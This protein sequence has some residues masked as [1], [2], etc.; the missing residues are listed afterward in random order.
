MIYSTLT[1]VNASRDMIDAFGGYNHNLR[2][3]ENEFYDMKNMTS[4]YYPLLSPRGGR[5]LYSYPQGQ[6]TFN[7]NGIIAKD[8][9][10]RVEGTKLFI[11]NNEIQG[12]V[13]TDGPKQLISMGAYLIIMP[14]KKYVNTKDFTEYGDIEAS[15]TTTGEV[16][17][18]LCSQDGEGYDDVTISETEPAEPVNGTLWIDSSNPELHILKQYSETSSMWVQIPT[19][20]IKI[21]CQGIAHAFE[22]FDGVK[23][24]GIDTENIPQL[25]DLEG[26]TSVIWRLYKDENGGA[27]DYIVVIGMLDAT[28]SQSSSITVSRRM[29]L[30]D[31]IIESGNRL[32][33][34]RYGP[35]IDGE[36]VNEIYASKLGDFKNWNVYMGLGSDSYAASCGTDGQW[37]GA[38]AHLGYPLFWK[39]NFVHK[40]YGNMPANYQIQTTACKG[41]QKG[42][43]RSMAIVGET[44]FYKSTN[45]VCA[46]DGSLPTEVSGQFGGIKYTALDATLKTADPL[47]C[48]AVA[49]ADHNKYYIS[50]KSEMDD[51]WHLFVFDTRMGMWHREDN[52]WADA[53]CACDDNMYYIDHADKKIKT[54]SDVRFAREE[55]V[56]WFVETGTL[57]LSLP[58]NK[59]ISR[60]NIR[61]SLK[62]GTRIAIYIE[63]DSCG[64]WEFLWDMVGTSLRSFTVPIR[65][66][67]CDHFR[68]KIE[69]VGQA[70]IFSIAKVIEQGSDMR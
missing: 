32:W 56:S 6:N 66:H 14:D 22:E 49:G 28:A 43:G 1:E 7:A 12:I 23:I 70:K 65:P 64:Q 55:V 51:N 19:T 16:S 52:T 68:L 10:C 17:F 18:T 53:F 13:L 45:G 11:N 4:A 21:S 2:I 37:T 42:A 5:G 40:V 57:G 69:G 15:F 62:P 50:M 3:S 20:Y 41:V 38:I 44:L 8:A 48:G 36:V 58:D 59:Y 61:M 26:Q 67:R 35:S 24:S 33:G 47:R 27:G 34:C 39:E 46:Y 54:M 25:A 30:M 29:P 60:M 9:L 31:F 63:Y